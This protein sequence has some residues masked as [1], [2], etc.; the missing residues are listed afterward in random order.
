MATKRPPPPA[1]ARLQVL[2]RAEIQLALQLEETKA[3]LAKVR[4]E[5]RAIKESKK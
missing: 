2:Q 5:I 4:A 3:T 1:T